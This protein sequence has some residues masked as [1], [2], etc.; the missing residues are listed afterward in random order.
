MTGQRQ[1][2]RT[3][4]IFYSLIPLFVTYVSLEVVLS[5]LYRHGTIAPI[6][7]WI[8]ENTD[9]GSTYQFD[10]IRGYRLLCWQ[11]FSQSVPACLWN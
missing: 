11:T 1:I 6:S 10:P 5:Y 4:K 7:V 8:N 9:S 3:R 2:T